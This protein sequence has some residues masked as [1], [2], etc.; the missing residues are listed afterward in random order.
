MRL[1][2]VPVLIALAVPARATPA[3]PPRKTPQLVETGRV[4]YRVNCASCHGDEGHG[5]GV[6]AAA[7]NPRPRNF[8]TEPFRLG[9]GVAQVFRTISQGIRGTGMAD[10]ADL[11]EEER[12]GLAYYVLEL[13]GR[14]KA[15]AGN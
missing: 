10:Y 4:A 2:L 9:D 3:A 11:P 1:A 8:A 14:G 13:R 7:L 6:S 12:W 5:D 15:S